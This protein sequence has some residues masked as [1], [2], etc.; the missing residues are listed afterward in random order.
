MVDRNFL[1][2]GVYFSLRLSFPKRLEQFRKKRKKAG[3]SKIHG[4]QIVL[5]EHLKW[6]SMDHSFSVFVGS[7]W[8]LTSN[9]TNNRYSLQACSLFVSQLFIPTWSFMFFIPKPITCYFP[10]DLLRWPSVDG[11]DGHRHHSKL[12]D[13]NHANNN[14][15]S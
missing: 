4:P 11:D 13:S 14:H 15:I 3:R 12:P 6:N 9:F 1:V 5:K 7:E 8:N 10:T 2:K